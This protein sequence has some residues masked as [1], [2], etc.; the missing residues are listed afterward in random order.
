MK[1]IPILDEER[2]NYEDFAGLFG[3]M[4]IISYL[5]YY[6]TWNIYN[7]EYQE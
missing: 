5:I 3:E 4:K 2:L 1:E 6:E 7:N